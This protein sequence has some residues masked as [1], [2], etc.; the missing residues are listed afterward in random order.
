MGHSDLTVG[1]MRH[2]R[3]TPGS[4]QYYFSSLRQ[5]LGNHVNLKLLPEYFYQVSSGEK[6]KIM[7]QE[8]LQDIDV[9]YASNGKTIDHVICPF[10]VRQ[11]LGLDIPVIYQPLGEFPRGAPGFL[12]A[13]RYFRSGDTITFSSSA[14]RAIYRNLVEHMP[15]DDNVLPFGI[16]TEYFRPLR[17][18]DGVRIRRDLGIKD[19]A[20]VFLYVGRGTSEKNIHALLDCFR[21]LHRRH[22]QAYLL[23]LGNV[24]DVPF[25]EF[26]T[27]PYD[28][29]KLFRGLPLEDCTVNIRFFGGVSSEELPWF[30]SAADAF[31]NLTLHHDENF[32]YTQVEAMA[33][34]LPL[35][36]SDWGGLRDTVDPACGFRVPVHL[37]RRGPR[38]DRSCVVKAMQWLVEHPGERSAMG[39]QSRR[40]AI[41]LY[42]IKA[43]GNSMHNLISNAVQDNSGRE[44]NPGRL[45]G[46]GE[47]LRDKMKEYVQ[48]REPT[49]FSFD[50]ASGE[51]YQE[52]IRPYA[53]SGVPAGVVAGKNWMLAS[54]FTRVDSN[55]LRVTDPL[56]PF[57]YGP[58]TE[59][60]KVLIHELQSCGIIAL[61]HNGHPRIAV[62][63]DEYRP[64]LAAG[65]ILE[66]Y[67]YRLPP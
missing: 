32:G 14:D 31:V 35:V 53:G 48:G 43:H 64:L 9:L 44:S 50:D 51:L 6:L 15:C 2:G 39:E 60:Q 41:A 22:P 29:K 7:M 18:T 61:D 20:F 42:D 56:W 5:Q 45:S 11:S 63:P 34:G 4:I 28:L 47:R 23:L 25:R 66:C 37:T 49:L 54:P 24:E 38:V 58:V 8:F 13:Y 57:E 36:T 33:C 16:D 12:A 59:N 10:I 19:D 52:L 62:T 3:E 46:I 30:Y 40:R 17:E 55:I 26:G 27:G 1:L 65:V 21:W 67:E